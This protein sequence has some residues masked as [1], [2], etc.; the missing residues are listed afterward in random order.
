WVRYSEE[1]RSDLANLR[2]MRVRFA[3]GR[4]FPLSEI[5]ELSVDRGVVSINHLNGKREIK[6]EADIAK[7]DVS[8]SDLTT[9]LKDEIVPG[10]LAEFPTVTALYE[11]QNREQE[12]SQQSM[13]RIIPI[14]LLLMLF[15]IALTFRSISQ[16]VAVF[17]LIPFGFIGVAWG[18]YLLGLPISFFSVLGIIALV[19]ILV[20]DALVFVTTYNQN[21]KEGMNQMNALFEAG[22]S[23]FRPIVLTSVTTFAGL[24]P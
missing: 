24:A 15:S 10:I 6:V 16:T 12:K 23:R 17:L 20:N 19:G 3:D 1:D 11:G 4:E 9:N 14:I 2:E 5:A 22:L 8:V 13:Q 18:H 21:L 7:D